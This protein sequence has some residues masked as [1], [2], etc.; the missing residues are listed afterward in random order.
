MYCFPHII[1]GSADNVDGPCGANGLH[2]VTAGNALHF[3]LLTVTRP[4][5]RLLPA[6]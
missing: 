6:D 3:A 5:V 4:M 2:S 1:D